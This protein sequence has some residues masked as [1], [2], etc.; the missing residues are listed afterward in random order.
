MAEFNVG[1]K[2]VHKLFGKGTVIEVSGFWG[3]GVEFEKTA[4]CFHD[5]NGKGKDKRC[6]YCIETNLSHFK[7]TIDRGDLVEIKL[8][9]NIKIEGVVIGTEKDE[10]YSTPIPK[11][12]VKVRCEEKIDFVKLKDATLVRKCFSVG[13]QIILR[14]KI[15]DR[16]EIKNGMIAKVIDKE[17]FTLCLEFDSDIKGHN[18]ASSKDGKRK[19]KDGCCWWV[20]FG[21]LLKSELCDKEYLKEINRM[22]IEKLKVLKSGNKIV[23][24][25]K[26]IYDSILI[27]KA[28]VKCNPED[29]FSYEVGLKLLGERLE[30]NRISID[31]VIEKE[32]FIR[33]ENKYEL[34]LF[35]KAVRDRGIKWASG[36][37]FA[38]DDIRITEPLKRNGFIYLRFRSEDRVKLF[39]SDSEYRVDTNIVDIKSIKL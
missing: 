23:A 3:I 22:S 11:G 35:E 28:E 25:I 18:N 34:G 30:Q 39:Y 6:Y 14:D 2:V 33:A 9:F 4:S 36:E 5:C 7:E 17:D 13:D 16:P 32:Y 29:K 21:E 38:K 15:E 1:D 8:P 19:G 24:E 27:S 31:T 26:N 37:S 12:I 20:E 10:C